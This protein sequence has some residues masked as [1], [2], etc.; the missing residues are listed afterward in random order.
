WL[1]NPWMKHD[2]LQRG[3][4][5]S[6]R[7]S[8][9]GSDWWTASVRARAVQMSSDGTVAVPSSAKRV[10]RFMRW[11]ARDVALEALSF[12]L[13]ASGAQSRGLSTPRIGLPYFHVVP[14]KYEDKFRRLL[15]RLSKNH[16][17][18]SY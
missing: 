15:S 1:V 9:T 5:R 10:K 14:E 2:H 13:R 11:R 16:V 7:D 6:G 8:V 18:I 3:S 17:F 4:W 12:R